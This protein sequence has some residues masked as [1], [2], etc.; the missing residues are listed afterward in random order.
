VKEGKS[1]FVFFQGHPEYE[2]STLLREYRRDAERYFRGESSAHPSIP[3]G[4]FDH[5]TECALEALRENAISSPNHEHSAHLA[6]ALK[7][8][9]I[10]NTWQT[11]AACIYRN[12]LDLIQLRK[13]STQHQKH[14]KMA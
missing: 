8:S 3:R 6:T 7:T 1:L 9:A 14:A 4:Y 2:S 13:N 10:E 5:A 11:T 12:W